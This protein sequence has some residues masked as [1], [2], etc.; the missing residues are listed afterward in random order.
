M[1]AS[2]TRMVGISA[3]VYLAA[4]IVSVVA[5][6]LLI[7]AAVSG[8]AAG[9]ATGSSMIG[10]IIGIVVSVVFL[11]MLWNVNGYLKSKGV[12]SGTMW[13]MILAALIVAEIVLSLIG[14]RGASFSTTGAGIWAIVLLVVTVAKGVMMIL[15]GVASLKGGGGAFKGAAILM[16]IAGAVTAAIIT[17]FLQPFVLIAYAIV[18]AV[19]MFGLAKSASA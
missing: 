6:F 12:N 7:R 15:F 11:W 13:V 2:Q 18:L 3:L 4:I 17:I 1:N 19:A 8:A 10:T 16:I 9:T 5:G 14:V